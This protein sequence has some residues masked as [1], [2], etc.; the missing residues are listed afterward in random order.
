MKIITCTGSVP[1]DLDTPVALTILRADIQPLSGLLS[2]L[3]ELTD[4]FSRWDPI[5]QQTILAAICHQLQALEHRA[6]VTREALEDEAIG[7][8]DAVARSRETEPP[9]LSA[10]VRNDSLES[11]ELPF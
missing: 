9:R 8:F 5:D 11:D 10:A 6:C 2:S 7:A 4:R 1:M 3:E